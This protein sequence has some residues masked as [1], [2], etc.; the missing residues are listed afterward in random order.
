VGN[1][2]V[3]GLNAA[4]LLFG[5]F[6]LIVGSKLARQ[7]AIKRGDVDED[8]DPVFEAGKSPADQQYLPLIPIAMGA[9]GLVRAAHSAGLL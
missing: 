6:M 1:V 4:L 5:L 8:G 7:R 2:I 3:I 9:Y